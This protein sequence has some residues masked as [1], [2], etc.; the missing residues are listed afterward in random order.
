LLFSKLIAFKR[1]DP[2]LA[3]SI[4]FSAVAVVNYYSFFDVLAPG[5]TSSNGSVK[6]SM[7]ALFI[8]PVLLLTAIQLLYSAGILHLVTRAFFFDK[9]DFV[10]AFFSSS[11]LVLMFS[12]FYLLVPSWGPYLFLVGP[13][14]DTPSSDYVL[15]AGWLAV[16]L[17]ASSAII[18]AVYGLR[19]KVKWPLALF[20]SG[21]MFLI[22]LA[23]AEG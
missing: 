11:V 1:N 17:L 3:V 18:T 6:E 15:L 5:I 16:T 10:K 23:F 8:F 20:L 12:F 2:M 22:V 9:R 21:S 14:R 13:L 4:L 7:G 19:G